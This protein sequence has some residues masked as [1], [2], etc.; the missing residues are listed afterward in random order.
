MRFLPPKDT[1]ASTSTL[2]AESKSSLRPLVTM[3]YHHAAEGSDELSGLED[4]V[5]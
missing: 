3:Q 5:N 1:G 4:R 2:Q